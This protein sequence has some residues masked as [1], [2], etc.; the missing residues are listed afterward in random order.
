MMAAETLPNAEEEQPDARIRLAFFLTIGPAQ[1][2]FS[3]LRMLTNPIF[4]YW[5][6]LLIAAGLFVNSLLTAGPIWDDARRV[7]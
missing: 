2:G 1:R 3:I 7:W 4:W 6:C 5:T